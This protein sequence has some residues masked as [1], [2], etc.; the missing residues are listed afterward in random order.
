M[1]PRPH[2]SKDRS[3]RVSGAAGLGAWRQCRLSQAALPCPLPRETVI[4]VTELINAMKQIKHIPE[5]KLVSLVSAL[6]D[7]KDGKVNINDL[8]KV[9]ARPGRAAGAAARAGPPGKRGAA[10]Q[11]PVWGPRRPGGDVRD[12][13]VPGARSLGSPAS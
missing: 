11:G 6:D 5:H 13:S 1:G 2:W 4:S 7:N 12:P 8:V 3:Q 10:S 9:G